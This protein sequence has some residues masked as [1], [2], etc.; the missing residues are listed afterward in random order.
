MLA[1]KQWSVGGRSLS[2]GGTLEMEIFMKMKVMRY[3]TN[4]REER[5]KKEETLKRER[6]D[7]SKKGKERGVKWE[8]TPLGI[9]PDTA[10]KLI[11]KDED[12]D[13]TEAGREDSAIVN[14][15]V[16]RHKVLKNI[17]ARSYVNMKFPATED[18]EADKFDRYLRGSLLIQTTSPPPPPPP[19]IVPIRCPLGVEK[20]KGVGA[21]TTPHVDL[22]SRSRSRGSS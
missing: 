16:V 15:Q 7:M 5:L 8:T 18:F 3:D 10:A 11:Y 20:E 22:P 17:I 19:P 21:M 9:L 14:P 6:E 2:G 13:T 4:E 12:D 1:V